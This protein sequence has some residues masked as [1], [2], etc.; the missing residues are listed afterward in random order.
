MMERD[1]GCSMETIYE[2]C[3]SWLC[4][5]TGEEISRELRAEEKGI[6]YDAG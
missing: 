1:L 5:G 4:E 3:E 2:L 6:I